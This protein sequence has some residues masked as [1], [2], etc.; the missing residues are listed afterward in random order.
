MAAADFINKIQ[1]I[2]IA[3]Y[4]RPADPAGLAFWSQRADQQGIQGVINAF[5]TSQ[6]SLDLYGNGPTVL[7]VR[8]IYNQLF[9]REPDS[10]GLRYWSDRIDGVSTD[11]TVS[12]AQA[13]LF[14]LEGAQDGNPNE[15]GTPDLTIIN[16][17]AAV[18]EVFTS[19]VNTQAEINAYGGSDAAQIA[20]DFLQTI[21]SGTN[22]NL[23]DVDPTII[24]IQQ[25]ATQ[26]GPNF[27][28]TTGLDTMTGGAGDD[29]FIA[30]NRGTQQVTQTGDTLNG[31]GGS[32]DSLTIFGAVT[33]LPFFQRIENLNLIEAFGNYNLSAVRDLDVNGAQVVSS[34]RTVTLSDVKGATNLT[35]PNLGSISSVVL[36]DTNLSNVNPRDISVQFNKQ[37]AE[38]QTA[39]LTVR[40]VTLGASK[41]NVD[42]AFNQ[43]S[44]SSE[45]VSNSLANQLTLTSTQTIER[46]VV[47]GVAGLDLGRLNGGTFIRTVDASSLG[48]GISVGVN[49]QVGAG[50][51]IGAGVTVIG[52]AFNDQISDSAGN[53]ALQGGGGND[54]FRISVG[55]DSIEGGAGTDT[56]VSDIRAVTDAT[57][58]SVFSVENIATLG[59]GVESNITLGSSA[60]RAGITGIATANNA[61]ST[62]VL[63]ADFTREFTVNTRNGQDTV[64]F[65]LGRTGG[66]AINTAD[67]LTP[68]G[69]S[70]NPESKTDRIVVEGGNSLFIG[71]R[72]NLA[73]V[74]NADVRVSPGVTVADLAVR[75]QEQ[76]S[77]GNLLT[78]PVV[79]TDDEGVS[80]QLSASSAATSTVFNLIDTANSTAISGGFKSVYL[81]TSGDDGFL[82]TGVGATFAGGGQGADDLTG[83]TGN[84]YL[85]G[86]AGND[87]LEGFAGND[88]LMGGAGNDTLSGGDGND[89]LNGGAGD[90]SLQDGL[91]ADVVVGAD[92]DDFIQLSADGT[93]DVFAGL[94]GNDQITTLDGVGV[95][96]VHFRSVDG[97]DTLNGFNFTNNTDFIAFLDNGPSGGVGAVNF[98][99][100][101][102]TTGA[103]GTQFSAADV[104]TMANQPKSYLELSKAGLAA[105]D[106]LLHSSLVLKLSDA[107]AAEARAGLTYGKSATELYLVVAGDV[108][109]SVDIYFESSTADQASPTLIGTFVGVSIADINVTDFGV[110]STV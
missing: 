4:G 61:D 36:R 5:G 52:T 97:S 39:S 10:S 104:T 98:A 14:I 33:Q 19:A 88:T 20:R 18:A 6:E 38:Q 40:N 110:Y 83:A 109:N 55:S 45:G 59:A 47:T 50:G 71:V 23:V 13:A 101:D 21:N 96:E 85:S 84:D 1:K 70:N 25:L 82:Y 91:G 43:V 79:T 44:L 63:G 35:L 3:Y 57:F 41:L 75:I 65:N 108:A 62:V 34:L 15:G 30:D 24:R 42:G 53:D 11:P 64:Q 103:A 28:L 32:N 69:V 16:K 12:R 60:N 49:P 77:V 90:D 107:T 51:S 68:S 89:S 100:S 78:G 72:L 106:S 87:D 95:D 29:I 37:T 17:K 105:A 99:A 26:S 22:V 27:I 54:V 31:A 94:S 58:N 81:G 66:G 102:T 56:L 80:I 76:D 74:G 93:K 9:N 8:A 92:G 73:N 46:L 67:G 2:Y 48:G 7:F 86:D